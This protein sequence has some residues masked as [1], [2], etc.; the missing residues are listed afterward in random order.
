MSLNQMF[1]VVL[2]MSESS[3][4]HAV[5]SKVA[6][7]FESNSNLF[8]VIYIIIHIVFFN[9]HHHD[10]TLLFIRCGSAVMVHK[11]RYDS[12]TTRSYVIDK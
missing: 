1:V 9:C 11:N 12:N 3:R 2:V 10:Q 4:S 6:G 8:K 7:S 5:R